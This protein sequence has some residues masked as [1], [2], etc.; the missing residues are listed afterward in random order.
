MKQVFLSLLCICTLAIQAQKTD[1]KLQQEVETIIK[2]FNGE[3]GVYVKDLHSNKI[4]AINADSIFPTASMVKIP[5]LIGVTNKINKGE[6]CGVQLVSLIFFVL[7]Q[8]T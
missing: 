7:T 1:K 3:V 2:G 5:I 6:F 8:K 4:V